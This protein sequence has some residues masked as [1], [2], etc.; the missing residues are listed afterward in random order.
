MGDRGTKPC[1][2]MIS[3]L[4][5]LRDMAGPG[6]LTSQ[7]LQFPVLTE[8][9]FAL[10]A[11]PWSKAFPAPA[12]NVE[13]Q[14]GRKNSPAIGP[15]KP[16]EGAGAPGATVTAGDLGSEVARNDDATPACTTDGSC[17]RSLRLGRIRSR[18]RRSGVCGRV[19]SR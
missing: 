3:R 17:R 1:S 4:N 10:A 6:R 12:V 13:R 8:V 15:R 2:S 11:R 5:C 9:N 7:L 14:P 18:R 16:N 19:T